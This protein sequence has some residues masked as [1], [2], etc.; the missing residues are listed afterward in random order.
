[1]TC[2]RSYSL[3]QLPNQLQKLLSVFSLHLGS[4]I[5]GWLWAGLLCTE[6]GSVRLSS[7]APG[8]AW[9]VSGLDAGTRLSCPE[10]ETPS[11]GVIVY[12]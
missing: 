2:A 8:R 12:C 4:V 6:V 1:M 9:V 3:G 7:F 10:V 11:T 5:I